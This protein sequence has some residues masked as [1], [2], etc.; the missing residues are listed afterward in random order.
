[1]TLEGLLFLPCLPFCLFTG[2]CPCHRLGQGCQVL[3][4]R[5]L[6]MEQ[7]AQNHSLQE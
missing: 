3:P 7:S 2:R 5:F 1:M 4:P 6:E